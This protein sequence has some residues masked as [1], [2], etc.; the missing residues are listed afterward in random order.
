MAKRA[1]KPKSR[2]QPNQLKTLARGLR[3]LSAFTPEH[4]T[5]SLTELA[6]FMALDPATVS[7][8]VS[9]LEQLGYL[10]RDSQTRAYWLTARV[11]DLGRAVDQSNELRALARPY[12]ETL[13]EKTGETVELAAREAGQLVVMETIESRQRVAV[14]GWV[15]RHLPL[16]CT[17]QGKVLLAELAP[18]GLAQILDELD[19]EALGPNT[20]TN[21][22]S[23]EKELKRT[24]KR[25]Y[26]LNN[27]E[28]NIGIQAIAAPIRSHT[29]SVDAALGIAMPIGRMTISE[30]EAQ[31]ATT[32]IECADKISKAL[33]YPAELK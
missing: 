6:G 3:V 14:R 18:T 1:L 24:A 16:Y 21:R 8:F 33:G 30:M 25:G 11:L 20:I 32:V 23:L 12:L 19:L 7:R 31:L 17:A 28:M 22:V 13:A 9:T 26:G 29:G 10:R 5:L 27:N 2:S 15:G 4:P